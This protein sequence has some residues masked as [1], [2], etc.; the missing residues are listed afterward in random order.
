MKKLLAIFPIALFLLAM[1]VI[2]T[3][4]KVW[5]TVQKYISVTFSYQEIDYGTLTAGSV[6]VSAPNQE[7]GIYNA[8]IDTN[9]Y[10]DVYAYGS[11]F[12]DGAG[13]TFS[14]SNLRF[15]CDTSLDKTTLEFSKA[16]S[17]TS[18]LIRS[19]FLN[20]DTLNYHAYY[21]SIPAK[22]Y[23]TQYMA[24]VTIDYINE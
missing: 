3:D 23:P 18:Q 10:Y 24:L 12:S 15:A 4:V 16:L 7:S 8:T 13:H 22:Q 5:A 2:A 14:I 6:N 20:T 9:Y 17:E 21:L 19:G 1:P 11:D